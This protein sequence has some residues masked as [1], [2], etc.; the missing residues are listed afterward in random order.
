RGRRPCGASRR[1]GT[2]DRGIDG[3]GRARGARR[4]EPAVRSLAAGAA[5]AGDSL[6]VFRAAHPIARSAT[7]DRHA[8]GQGRLPDPAALQ[9]GGWGPLMNE[10][11][12][13]TDNPLST[14][15]HAGIGAT[16][17]RGEGTTTSRPLP[18]DALIIVPV[19]N[20]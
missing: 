1:S 13:R 5:T 11:T 2:R 20:V 14:D 7:R 3:S 18:E 16:E 15:A 4:A 17:G 12:I 6:W 19:R 9:S 10:S 8:R